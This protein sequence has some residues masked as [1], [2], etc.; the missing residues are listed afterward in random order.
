[1]LGRV[2]QLIFTIALVLVAGCTT[3]PPRQVDA[4][5]AAI[6][7]TDPQLSYPVEAQR[8]HA[9][10]RVVVSAVVDVSGKVSE[11]RVSE[12][13][14]NALLDAAALRAAQS[15]TC[16]PFV[17]PETGKATPVS[18]SKPYVFSL[19]N[20]APNR[21]NALSLGLP[22]G[23]LSYAERIR[24]VVK[25]NLLVS[26]DN[27][28]DDISAV[29]KVLLG[30]DGA[31]L[32][33]TLEKSSGVKTYDDAVLKAIERSSPLPLEKPGQVGTKTIVLTFRP[34]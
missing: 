8:A 24:R 7:C 30:P 19:L 9:Q 33:A 6:V 5:T 2:R 27:L 1:M 25:S 18:F 31:V 26:D 28:P 34:K 12:S 10:G 3:P 4:R 22:S 20:D 14:G 29:V 32:R 13:S 16:T 11:T 21:S 15:K 23:T 17:D